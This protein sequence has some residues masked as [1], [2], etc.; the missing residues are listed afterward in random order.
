MLASV[1]IHDGGYRRKADA[2]MRTKAWRWTE[3]IRRV[4][5]RLALAG[6]FLCGVIAQDAPAAFAQQAATTVIKLE[7]GHELALFMHTTVDSESSKVGDRV[8]FELA[9]TVMSGNQIVLPAGWAVTARVTKVRHA[10]KSNCQRGAVDWKLDPMTAPDGTKVKLVSLRGRYNR[11]D[12]PDKV[13]FTTTNEKIEKVVEAPFLAV[14]FLLILPAEII[15][16]VGE[17]SG[18]APCGSQPG[19]PDIVE[20]RTT[21]YAAVAHDVNISASRGSTAN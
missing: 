15:M 10:G 19:A 6:T 21:Q 3:R 18:V 14:V 8:E 17:S 7:R 5:G 11:M 4:S 16:A 12:A 2:N 9:R 13:H 20:A 1:A